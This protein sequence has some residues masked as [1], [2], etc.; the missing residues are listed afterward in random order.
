MQIF[1]RLTVLVLV[2]VVGFGCQG[3]SSTSPVSTN[4]ETTNS[5]TKAEQKEIKSEAPVETAS[6]GSLATPTEAYKTAHA[7]RKK[8]DVAGLK[9]VMSKDVLE[10][11]SMMGE[12]Q[13]KSIDDMLKEM[14]A[15]PQADKAE[16]R[17]EKINGDKAQ[18][19]Y[20]TETGGWK[21][22]DFEKVDGKW[23]LSLPSTEDVNGPEPER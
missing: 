15:K 23:L 5:T 9:Q 12:D 4:S 10:F 8:C 19:Q 6:V 13:K 7:L 14:C 20:L 16:A 17:N 22:M 3:G 18:V 21:I 11:M 1:I 2:G